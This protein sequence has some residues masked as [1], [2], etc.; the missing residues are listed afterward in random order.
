VPG[1]FDHR[2]E[3]LGWARARLEELTTPDEYRAVR[4]TTL[5]AHYTDAHYAGLIW[6]ALIRLGFTEG[7]VLEPGC[8]S[9]NFIGLAP[10][11]AAMTGVERDPVTAAITAALYPHADIRA[12]SFADTRI[13]AA[14]FD[15]AV[16]N[17]PFGKFKLSDPA[18]NPGRRLSI[19]NHFIVK[20]LEL[21]RPGGMVALLTSRYTMDSRNPEARRRIA[22]LGDL[23]AAV[24]L[25]TGAHRQAAGT[26]VVTDL[27][28]LS[29]REPGQPGQPNGWELAPETD[30]PGGPAR[31]NEYFTAHLEYVLGEMRTGRGAHGENDV[32]VVGSPDA[33]SVLAAAL[34]TA[35]TRARASGLTIS[36]R[37]RGTEPAPL[38]PLP[39]LAP[40]DDRIDG[41]I[42]AHP[43]GTFTRLTA[44]TP[45][46]YEPPAAQ[47]R[48]LRQ[49]IGLRDT[50]LAL[51]R[52]EAASPDDTEEITGLRAELNACYED[53][54]DR[55]GPVKRFTWAATG[56]ADPQTGEKTQ[57][58]RRP[59]QGGFRNDPLY[60]LVYA[61]EEN[62]DPGSKTAVRADIFTQRVVVPETPLLGA[63]TADEALAICLNSFGE[64][65]LEEITRLLGAASEAGARAELGTLV[66]DEPGTG[67]LVWAPLYLSGDVRAKL[68]AADG[69]AVANPRF[70]P[71]VA[72]LRAVIPRDLG[73]AE[74]EAQLGAGWIAPHYVQHFL[75][76]TLGDNNVT[77]ERSRGR[78]WKV[79]GGNRKSVAA[80][81]TWGTR[82]VC[83][84]DIA[85]RLLT[86]TAEQITVKRDVAGGGKVTDH[87]ATE[88]AKQKARDLA[89][90]FSIW[91][92]EDT[93]RTRDLARVYNDRYNAVVPVSFDGV[94]LFTPGLSAALTL[95]AHQPPAIARIIYQGSAGLVHDTGAGKTLE[96]IIGVRERQRLGLSHKPC[97]VVQKHKL[98]DFRDEF[99]RAYPD[100]RLL[101]ADT[102]DL[103]GNKRRE[104]I[105]RCA[106]GNPAAIIMSR[107]AF[108]SIPVSAERIAAF[109]KDE[110]IAL[111]IAIEDAQSSGEDDRTIKQI[112]AELENTKERRKEQ[113]ARIGQDRGLCYED[114]GIDY[115][116][117]DEARGYRK[118]PVISSLPGMADPG[119]ARSL[120]LLLKL[121][122]HHDLYGE[123]R[124]CLADATPFTNKIAEIYT[125]L[126]YLHYD[127]EDFDSWVRTFGKMAVAYEM[128]PGGDFKAKARLREIIN[129]VDLHLWLRELTDFKLKDTLDLRLPA[130]VGGKPEIVQV[131]ASDELL[132]YADAIRWRYEHLPKGP[133]KKGADNHLKIQGDAIRA[134]LDL[135]LVGRST[136]QPQKADITADVIHGK[137]LK[138]RDDVYKRADGT[139]HPVRGSL[140][141][142]F[143]SLGTP[144][145]TR[146]LA[147][148]E[149]PGPYDTW[150][151]YT[152]LRGQLTARGMPGHLIRFI[153]QAANA[154]QKEEL[155]R[156]CRNGEVAVLVGSTEKLGTGTNVQDRAV[157]LIQVTA[158]WNWDEPHQE[159]GRV[160]RQG[161]RNT[162]FFCI[163][164]VTSPSAD[165]IKWERARQKE[166]S[167]RALMSGHIE[168]RTI[169][170][171][172][173]DLSSAEV[174]A[175]ASGDLR[176]LERA[177]L[178]G[179]LSRLDRLRRAWAQNQTALGYTIRNA[180]EQIAG[181]ERAIGLIDAALGRRKDT[182]GDAFAMTV[183]GQRHTKRAEAADQLRQVLLQQIAAIPRGNIE[184]DV[185]LGEIG[186]FTLTA[187][188]APQF[189]NSITLT[190]AGI[191]DLPTSLV[192][193]HRELPEKTGIIARLENRLAGLE[194][195][196]SD[197]EAAIRNLGGE[198]AQARASLGGSFPQQDEYDLACARLDALESDLVGA[199]KISAGT[200]PAEQGTTSVPES[201]AASIR[202]RTRGADAAPGDPA[203]PRAAQATPS[204]DPTD[205]AH[206]R[207]AEAVDTPEPEAALEDSRPEVTEDQAATVDVV[208]PPALVP[209]RSEDPDRAVGPEAADDPPGGLVIEHHQQGTLVRGTDKNDQQV[210]R[211]LHQHGFKWSGNLGAWYLPRPWSYST[212]GRR[213]AGL[214]AGLR[215]AQHSFTMRDQLLAVDAAVGPS[216]EPLPVPDQQAAAPDPAPTV[217]SRGAEL[218]AAPAEDGKRPS[219]SKQQQDSDRLAAL[220]KAR[221]AAAALESGD[222]ERS[223][224]LIDEAELLYPNRGVSWDAARDQVRAAIRQPR[225]SQPQDGGSQPCPQEALASAGT[226]PVHG[227]SEETEPEPSPVNNS[228]LAI[229]LRR[230]PGFTRLL[231]QDG[232]PAHGGSRG[233][234]EDGAPNAGASQDLNYS[235]RGIEITI[236]GPGFRRHGLLTWSQI[237]S[238]IDAGVT[239]ARLGIIIAADR[240]S[241]FCRTRHDELAAAGKCDPDAAQAELDQIR[242]DAIKAVVDAAL[243]TRGAA[244]P[245]PPARPGNPAYY[246]A[247][248]ITRPDE[249]ASRDE[250]SVLERLNR[251]RTQIREPQPIT[252]QEIKATIRLWIGNDLPEYTRALGKPEKMRAWISRQASGPASRPSRI[253]YE[254]PGVRGGRWY[255]ASPEGL[256]TAVGNDD[257]AETLIPWEE[258]PAWIQP[259]ITSSLCDRL[260]AAADSH[261]ALFFR[262]V[263]AA[264]HPQAHLE[265]PSK[266]QEEHSAERLRV[267]IAEVW[268]AIEAAPPPAPAQLEAVRR[269]YRDSGPVQGDLFDDPLQARENGATPQAGTTGRPDERAKRA[270]PDEASATSPPD[271]PHHAVTT[272]ALV[273][274]STE[275]ADGN[276]A[277]SALRPASTV[278]ALTAAD[279]ALAVSRLPA[280]TIGDMFSAMDAGQPLDSTFRRLA[281]YSGERGPGEPDPGAREVV[282]AEPAG[283]NIRVTVDQ[284]SRVG[285]IAWQVIAEWL[286]SGLTPGRRQVVMEAART[287]LRFAAANASFRAVGEA[288]LAAAAEEELRNLAREAVSAIIDDARSAARGQPQQPVD[289]ESTALKRISELAAALPARQTR[290]RTPVSQL[291][292]GDIIGH[293]GY[294]LQ[295]LRVTA[296]PC[297]CDGGIEITGCLTAPA[298]DEP[299]GQITF[300][301]PATRNPDPVVSLIPLPRHP[302]RSLF[303]ESVAEPC[304]E[305]AVGQGQAPDAAAS[306][307]AADSQ[308]DHS[309]PPSNEENTMPS[310]QAASH[311]PDQAPATVQAPASAASEPADPP[312]AASSIRQARSADQL[313]DGSDLLGELDRVLDAIIER[314]RGLGRQDDGA[315]DDFA[316][317]RAAFTLLRNAVATGS[318]IGSTI[319]YSPSAAVPDPEDPRRATREPA[320]RPDAGPEGFDDIRSAFADLRHVLDLPAVGRHVRGPDVPPGQ[321]ASRLLDQAAEEAQAC[322]R[323]YR[324]TPEW[325]RI[326]NIGRAAQEL[327]RAIREAAGDYWA[328]I[329]QDIR[330]RGFARTLASRV[331][332]AVSGTAHVLAGRLERAGQGNTRIWRAAWGL[333]RATATFADRIMAYTPPQRPDRMAGAR[334]IIDD[335]GTRDRSARAPSGV[336]PEREHAP[337]PVRLAHASFAARAARPESSPVA[338]PVHRAAAHAG[339][340]R[341]AGHG[342]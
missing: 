168:G 60:P 128:V 15:C 53:Y 84:R 97:F 172:D 289:D 170:I 135:R 142:V 341:Y 143:A 190:L 314:H 216:A 152:E 238:W 2:R 150:D 291:K 134:A 309:Q 275:A 125:W 229:A 324:D 248:M 115:L 19:H 244:A 273:P 144:G 308:A 213:V 194:Q 167:F 94:R 72:A 257:R 65:R 235:S 132:A 243:R 66:F 272:P 342:L 322:A 121:G 37:P 3:D 282:A 188:L 74:I 286:Q 26:D 71:N 296:P 42:Q 201:S 110:E 64:V 1:V 253:T 198:I 33:A 79:S 8:G 313:G 262:Q 47:A 156:A 14:Y 17:V 40:Q 225:P 176:L 264:V 83:A 274:A 32:T 99:L 196:R 75:R 280:F 333:H 315:R 255:G 228:D 123:T 111:E 294:K 277:A 35:V 323:W 189:A 163:R 76:E 328:E 166:Q 271:P 119:S 109:L 258:I 287:G 233:W 179:T 36:E 237:T 58:R 239:P 153:H 227:G 295:P 327:V 147:E 270:G 100:A 299:A 219:A 329:R 69:A 116:V 30:L 101:V 50:V 203:P 197:A 13:A 195:V 130:M 217:G 263:T 318:P 174:M 160:E 161:N 63:D 102:E 62:Y 103:T 182:R 338:E 208:Q 173:D 45:Q 137:W 199:S 184:R 82:D 334:R 140:I 185:A 266:E 81:S 148:D 141:L 22:A 210:R 155:F 178:E 325:Q 284:G 104:F 209:A 9:G 268:A 298:D 20:S 11:G 316:D 249:A 127:I 339:Q 186:G 118:S 251:L 222:H 175:A 297:H 59:P 305:V 154:Q 307:G 138:H 247:A 336:R 122:Y 162:E 28:I 300:T 265:D 31:V 181:R 16:G 311:D 171:P 41:L 267:V 164:V 89:D 77:V 18:H 157:G 108:R 70:E 330:V 180:E 4:R 231:T 120:D 136:S 332:L 259:G 254:T 252:P 221:Q 279:L 223:L 48:E 288:R 218:G 80:T 23:V 236:R 10:D 87:E 91:I 234:R 230:F 7:R 317:I 27:L 43:D 5:N 256:L 151:F 215:Q 301:L 113:V 90:R 158:P 226:Q 191:P 302:L 133:P 54:L 206:S 193:N 169:R 38:L 146:K 165:A 310:E 241:M 278:S 56:R 93:A 107:E 337:D 242:D 105:A 224:A 240:L 114:T 204:P 261:R 321:S 39:P 68:S 312:S 159:L 55:Y 293:P 276:E 21:T 250:N 98:G 124:V 207:T 86:G 304:P 211:L 232:P 245:V 306:P 331:C 61:L 205:P 57:S 12:E 340:R 269:A 335:L 34:E 292:T 129:A 192:L 51:L 320:H 44:G 24:R 260:I 92:W 145:R 126:R 29:R 183:A 290:Q 281:P 303:P 46:P 85:Q 52:A 326:T 319:G 214:T 88:A 78:K 49:L 6:D 95:R 220:D 112:E 67:R 106:T 117:L 25:P 131:P 73:P 96:T 200:Q 187:T 202:P 283:L 212:R 177:E 149:Q 285:V 139:D 246:T